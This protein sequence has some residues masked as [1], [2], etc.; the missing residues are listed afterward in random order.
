M[1]ASARLSVCVVGLNIHVPRQCVMLSF[2]SL[3]LCASPGCPPAL[4]TSFLLCPL[5]IELR[6]V[7]ALHISGSRENAASQC[8]H[9]EHAPIDR[10]R[11]VCSVCDLSPV[12]NVRQVTDFMI[13]PCASWAPPLFGGMCGRSHWLFPHR[14]TRTQTKCCS[15]F[16]CGCGCQGTWR[17]LSVDACPAVQQVEH[18]RP[19]ALPDWRALETLQAFGA[20]ARFPDPRQNQAS[21]RATSHGKNVQARFRGPRQ[22]SE[23]TCLGRCL[24]LQTRRRI[25]WLAS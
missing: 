18:Q 11:Y 19:F 21:P 22:N 20:M 14:T 9:R 25:E 23:G 1:A 17:V 6:L 3:V 2:C 12:S 24:C 10:S 16:H 15:H 7:C 5:G 4:R 13:S 8:T